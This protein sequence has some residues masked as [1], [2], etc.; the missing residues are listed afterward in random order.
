M[1]IGNGRVITWDKDNPFFENGGVLVKGTRI[2]KVGDFTELREMYP[3]EEVTDVK[4]RL[5][6]PGMI[7]MHTHIYSAFARGLNLGKPTPD[8]LK[9]LENMWWHIDKHLTLEDTRYSA[10]GTLTESIRLGV[11]TVVDHHASPYHIRDSLFTI[12]E[13]AKEIG[14]RASLCYET[15]D[16]DGME[17]AEE[18]VRE[19]IE[20]IR[21][22]RKDE[23]SMLKGMFGMHASFTLSDGTLDKARSEME[24]LDAGY[25]I[26]VAEGIDDEILCVRDHGKRV[27]ERLEEFGILSDKSLAIH[28]VHADDRELEILK[29]TNCNVVHNPESNMGN[30]VGTSPVVKMM[31]MGIKVGLG[32]DAYT[33]DMFESL[34]VAKILQSHALKDPQV[35]FMEAFRMQFENNRDIAGRI[36]GAELGILRENA[37]ADIITLDYD[38]LTPMNGNNLAGHAI[39][40]MSGYQ[41]RDTMING[42][43]VMK[44]RILTTIDLEKTM[45]KSREVSKRLWERL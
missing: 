44:D 12:G 16:R 11:T 26:H 43:F 18:G 10:Y 15:S 38:P 39:F 27:V 41:V 17:A 34:K 36:F 45:A 9:I 8:F 22:C 25:H 21:A 28:C 3:D 42:R 14:V 37:C 23:N 35:G 40:G 20:F 7:N 24:G 5:I 32:T 19:N 4:G 1:I 31:G 13:A 2:E 33:N 6:M 29:A 30:A